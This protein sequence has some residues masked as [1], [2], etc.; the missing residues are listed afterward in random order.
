M[1]SWQ[2]WE[3]FLLNLPW[4]IVNDSTYRQQFLKELSVPKPMPYSP[5]SSY[6]GL[7]RTPEGSPLLSTCP[8]QEE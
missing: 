1:G 2:D 7:L 6:P 5:P 8:G 4:N 3:H